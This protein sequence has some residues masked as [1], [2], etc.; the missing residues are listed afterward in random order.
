MNA[1]PNAMRCR[2]I[3]EDYAKRAERTQDAALKSTYQ[4]LERL[5]LD[6]APL[7]ESYDRSSDPRA[8]QRIYDM[9]DAVGDIRQ[10][11]A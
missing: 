9:I 4:R 8:K 7:A 5:W 10:N 3:A 2:R 1:M 11:V 6:M